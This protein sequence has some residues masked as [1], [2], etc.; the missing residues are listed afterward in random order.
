MHPD[1]QQ[2]VDQI[3]RF[4]ERAVE[5]VL[6]TPGADPLP[7]VAD[8]LTLEPGARHLALH[9]WNEQRSVALRVTAVEKD[10]R[11]LVRLTAK[12][13]FAREQTVDLVDRQARP[14]KL[15][16]RRAARDVH[17]EALRCALARRFAGWRLREI[18]SGA[19]LENSLSP[20][21][22][23]ALVTKGTRGWAAL[24]A[25]NEWDADGALTFG[26]IWLDY[27]RRREARV[28]VEGL[29]LFVPQARYL[30]T[31]LRLRHMNGNLFQ[32][33]LYGYD[34][35]GFEDPV[36]LRDWGNVFTQLDRAWETETPTGATTPE[37]QLERQVRSSLPAIAADLR[38]PVYGQVPAFSG[39]DRSLV[40]LLTVTTTGRLAVLELKAQEDL[41]LPLQGLD[42]WLRVNW[43]LKKGDFSARGYFPGL[44][45]QRQPPKLYFVAPALRFHPSN[46]TVL[47]YFS[48]EVETERVGVSEDWRWRMRVMHRKQWGGVEIGNDQSSSAGAAGRGQPE[49]GFGAGTG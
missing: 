47:R 29:A 23:R 36:D 9:A 2:M 25:A 33:M 14:D 8:C 21:F 16:D 48:P 27:L 3:L 10:Q 45:L 1:V 39:H 7:L 13:L 38:E 18:T 34:A 4:L 11:A 22:P 15:A 35:H 37:R 30:T 41:H 44:P 28:A 19:D 12:A 40:D 24:W 32:T 31:A 43:H 49:P 20:A 26:L 46:D 6:I 17:R 42:Y 5:P